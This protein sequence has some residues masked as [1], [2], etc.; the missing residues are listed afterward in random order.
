MPMPMTLK[1]Q[2]PNFVCVEFM[3][4]KLKLEFQMEHSHSFVGEKSLKYMVTCYYFSC[5]CSCFSCWICCFF[6]IYERATA[7]YNPSVRY[8]AKQLC[9]FWK[10]LSSTLWT[11]NWAYSSGEF[12]CGWIF[13]LNPVCHL[14]CYLFHWNIFYHHYMR[15]K[16]EREGEF[17]FMVNCSMFYHFRNR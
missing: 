10:A 11:T 6:L 15:N 4:K 8:I 16:T 9:P 14:F 3:W 5:C 2:I 7:L 13:Y 17:K 1:T 12:N